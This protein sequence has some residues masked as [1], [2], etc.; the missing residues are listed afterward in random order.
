MNS[1]N[2]LNDLNKFG[3]KLGLENMQ[4]M[5][6]YFNNPEQ[7][8]KI[9]HIAG[10][11]GK[12]STSIMTAQTLIN[13]DYKVA[14][15]TS[16]YVEKLNEN[17]KI[18]LQDISDND[19]EKLSIK[20]LN[21][22]DVLNIQATHYE[23]CTMIMF[24]YAKEQKVDFLVLEVGLGGR[25]DATNVVNADLSVIT[26]VSLDHTEIL[27]DTLDK[28]AYEKCGII[29]K[30]PVIIGEDIT[31]LI[32]CAEQMTDRIIY[33]FKAVNNYSLDY[34]NFKTI[35]T[36]NGER[37]V[38]NLFGVHQA[39][40]L[41]IVY[42]IVKFFNLNEK[43]FKA[44]CHNIT[45]PGRFEIRSR[46]P[47]V[48]VDGAHNE[49]AMRVL[50]ESLS[51]YNKDEIQLIFSLLKEKNLMR[52]VPI[53]KEMTNNVI[54]TDLSNIEPNRA[55]DSDYIFNNIDVENKA[56]FK[57]PNSAF[58]QISNKFK[59]NIICGSFKIIEEYQNWEQTNEM[60]KDK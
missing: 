22:I 9:I 15:Y 56:L 20:V 24:L 10:T 29:K 51:T 47:L 27:G 54:V 58:A 38:H 32:N 46:N 60:S 52:L 42:Q 34:E 3:I 41:A 6:K 40:N 31:E 30:A 12:G 16:P 49:A 43:A 53:I 1:I 2:K 11:N 50:K 44:M 8:Y 5:C 26:N 17:F 55:M 36:I 39:S 4:L 7:A 13:D 48:I 57:N 14:S 33:S 45:W 25:Y 37:Y 23:V 18:N 59:V 19:L 28:I 21:A 35:V